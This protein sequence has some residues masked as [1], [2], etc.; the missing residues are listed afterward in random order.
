MSQSL[1]LSRARLRVARGEALSAIAP[2]LRPDDDARRAGHAHRLVWLLFQFR[3]D[4]PRDFLW[5]DE[6][7]GKFMILSP[8]PPTDPHGLFDLE[9]KPFAPELAVGD[10]L[11]FALRA[12]PVV[13]RKG[14]LSSDDRALRRRGKRV[15][16]V[17]DALHAV[18]SDERNGKRDAI[19]ADAGRRWIEDQGAR[20]G[21]TPNTVVVTSYGRVDIADQEREKRRDRAGIAVMDLEGVLT[22]T[23]PSAFVAK[24]ERGFGGA[25][26]FGNG[27][28]MIK[29]I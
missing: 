20:A 16:V 3:Q 11:R 24:L 12:N 10:Q 27:L 4:G 5:R 6:G 13:A 26:G 19:T 21:F 17:M 1:Y 15:D 7:D 8:S 23:D 29:R 25:K 22:V 9:T 14:A 2:I 18:P 28:M